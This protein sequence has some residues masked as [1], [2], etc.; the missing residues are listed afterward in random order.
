MYVKGKDIGKDGLAIRMFG[1]FSV[2]RGAT[3]LDETLNK[4]RNLGALMEY[5]LAQKGRPVPIEEFIETIW[6]DKDWDNPGK[7]IQNLVYRLRQLIDSES[8]PSHILHIHGGYSWNAAAGYYLDVEEFEACFDEGLKSRRNNEDCKGAFLRA[9][10]T[11]RSDFLEES[12]FESWTIT[13]RQNLKNKY[14]ICVRE[15]LEAF[16][17]DGDYSAVVDI[18]NKAIA[19]DPYDEKVHV[20]Y[21]DALINLDRTA[22]ACRHYNTTTEFLQKTLGV[23]PSKELNEIYNRIKDHIS[24]KQYDLDAI[25]GELESIQDT[26]EGPLF[27]D[28]ESFNRFY[29]LELRRMLRNG[30]SNCLVLMTL[31]NPE[32]SV[33]PEDALKRA[34]STMSNELSRSLRKGDIVCFRTES[35]AVIFLSSITF[36]SA[37]TVAQRIADNFKKKFNNQDVLPQYKVRLVEAKI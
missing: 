5:L 25:M 26:A 8:T 19:I 35:Q 22:H 14:A 1:P 33:P 11:Y 36:E 29:D 7:V 31:S 3:I 27:C 13:I 18:C 21:I 12:L 2:Q 28:L 23:S 24:L 17:K 6:E 37:Q 20:A 10:E 15:L 32:L 9:L 30:Q 16:K 4:S 34:K